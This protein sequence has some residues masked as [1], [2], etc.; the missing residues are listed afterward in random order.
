MVGIIPKFRP[1]VLKVRPKQLKD[2]RKQIN[3]HYNIY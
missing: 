1:A 2:F 3:T